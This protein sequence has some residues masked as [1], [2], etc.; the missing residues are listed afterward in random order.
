M[1]FTPWSFTKDRVKIGARQ[2][3]APSS[4]ARNTKSPFLRLSSLVDM[5]F[6]VGHASAIGSNELPAPNLTT[7]ESGACDF[8]SYARFDVRLSGLA[9]S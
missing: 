6:P 7:L 9:I 3:V 5:K 1:R 2:S 8:Y 4:A